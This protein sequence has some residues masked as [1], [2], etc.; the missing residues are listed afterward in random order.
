[1]VEKIKSTP[2][3]NWVRLLAVLICGA[4]VGCITTARISPMEELLVAADQAKTR[5]IQL[6]L[7]G[8]YNIDPDVDESGKRIV[9]TSNKFG[10]FDLF[11]YDSDHRARRRLTRHVADD[12]HPALTADG[13]KVAFV[14]RRDD[15][16]GDIYYRD[17]QSSAWVSISAE[18]KA[19]NR[20]R[21]EGY[22]DSQPT[23]SPNNKFIYFVRRKLGATRE[24][25]VRYSLSDHSVTVI[26][27]GLSPA[28]SSDG[29]AMAFSRRGSIILRNL[30]NGKEWPLAKPKIVVDGH[31]S[32]ARSGKWLYFSRYNSDSNRDRQINGDDLPIISRIRLEDMRHSRVFPAE[33]LT[34]RNLRGARPRGISGQR[35]LFS[36][37]RADTIEVYGALAQN[38]RQ[39]SNEFS[40]AAKDHHLEV[41]RGQV[42]AALQN[43]TLKNKDL[44]IEAVIWG[45]YLSALEGRS[46]DVELFGSYADQAGSLDGRVKTVLRTA[47]KVMQ[48]YSLNFKNFDAVAMLQAPV[49]SASKRVARLLESMELNLKTVAKDIKL[50]SRLGSLLLLMRAKVA[51]Y[52]SQYARALKLLSSAPRFSEPRLRSERII[53]SALASSK[54]AGGDVGIAALIGATQ[55]P[56]IS[57]RFKA[58]LSEIIVKTAISKGDQ[59]FRR[60]ERLE[61]LAQKAPAVVSAIR[62]ER[63]RQF[64]KKSQHFLA[65]NELETVLTQPADSYPLA[66][67]AARAWIKVLQ[68]ETNITETIRTAEQSWKEFRGAKPETKKKAQQLFS[69]FFTR[70]GYSLMSMGEPGGAASVFKLASQIWPQNIDSWRGLVEANFMRHK[71]TN[72]LDGWCQRPRKTHSPGLQMYLCGL[73]TSYK[74]DASDDD[75]EKLNWCEQAIELIQ[76]SV[77]TDPSLASAHQ[78]LGW[79]YFQRHQLNARI[80]SK[81]PMRRSFRKVRAIVKDYL[82]WR[83]SDD[84]VLAIDS[85]LSS[86]Y[87]AMPDSA[88][89]VLLS[90]NLAGVFFERKN[91]QQALHYY[92]LR[93]AA[94]KEVPFPSKKV[95]Q[96]FMF[97][98]ARSGYQSSEYDLASYFARKAIQIAATRGDVA[99]QSAYN[100]YLNLVFLEAKKFKAC[101]AGTTTSQEVYRES[102][103]VFERINAESLKAL[104]QLRAEKPAQA[105]AQAYK[106]LSLLDENPKAAVRSRAKITV[107]IGGEN[108][109]IVEFDDFMRQLLLY[110]I[111]AD[112]HLQQQNIGA[113]INVLEQKEKMIA[114][115]VD[116][117]RKINGRSKN[118]ALELAY[119]RSNLAGAHMKLGQ[120]EFARAAASRGFL[121]LYRA[122]GAALKDAAL[123][124]LL[125]FW[126]LAQEHTNSSD[127]ER[128]QLLQ[129]AKDMW[130]PYQDIGDSEKVDQ[131]ERQILLAT[132]C[133]TGWRELGETFPCQSRNEE[134]GDQRKSK[135]LKS[136]GRARQGMITDQEMKATRRSMFAEVDY[137]LSYADHLGLT[138]IAFDEILIR[139]REG[140]N[141]FKDLRSKQLRGVLED[142]IEQLLKARQDPTSAVCQIHDSYAESV[143][144]SFNQSREAQ[145]SNKTLQGSFGLI[146][147]ALVQS[148]LA[149]YFDVFGDYAA[150]IAVNSIEHRVLVGPKEGIAE[151]LMKYLKDLEQSNGTL[152]AVTTEAIYPMILDLTNPVR[153]LHDLRALPTFKSR[154]QLIR[155]VTQTL[156]APSELRGK[157]APP[158]RVNVNRDFNQ[159]ADV[160]VI[161][162]EFKP[163]LADFSQS[164]FSQKDQG[165][166]VK[167]A[168][169]AGPKGAKAAQLIVVK[170]PHLPNDLRASKVAFLR[171]LSAFTLHINAAS[172][173][174]DFKGRS[175]AKSGEIIN[176]FTSHKTISAQGLADRGW[177]MVGHTG[178][179]QA[180][181]VAVARKKHEKFY[182]RFSELM[183][184]GQIV[185]AISS[186]MNALYCAELSEDLEGMEDTL[187]R[188]IRA[189]YAS[190]DYGRAY[191]LQ[192]KQIAL[193]EE[194]EYDPEEVLELKKEL[195]TIAI[196]AGYITKAEQLLED[197][198]ISQGGKAETLQLKAMVAKTRGQ[199]K[200]AFEFIEASAAI[201][202][203]EEMP[204]LAIER[205]MELGNIEREYFG[206]YSA[207]V[208][209]YEKA[210]GFAEAN[211]F[212]ILKAQIAI[213]YANTLIAIG[214]V[215][216]AQALL[217]KQDFELLRTRETSSATRLKMVLANASYLT[218][219][220][221]RANQTL[222]DIES[223]LSQVEDL[224]KRT[225]LGIDAANLRAMILCR[226]GQFEDCFAI[227]RANIQAAN[228]IGDSRKKTEALNNIGFWLREKGDYDRSVSELRLALRIDQQGK[229]K[230]AVAYDLRNLAMTEAM[231]NNLSEAKSLIKRSIEMS[232]ELRMSYNLAQSHLVLGDVLGRSKEFKASGEEFAK[233]LAVAKSAGLTDLTWRAQSALGRLYLDAKETPKAIESFKQAVETLGRL[234]TGLGSAKSRSGF[235]SDQGFNAVFEG[236]ISALVQAKEHKK[237]WKV[238]QNYRS[239]SFVES[240]GEITAVSTPQ[241]RKLLR[242]RIRLMTEIESQ[243]RRIAVIDVKDSKRIKLEES[244]DAL[245]GDL[246]IIKDKIIRADP[247]AL[248]VIAD[249]PVSEL[250]LQKILANNSALIDYMVTQDRIHTWVINKQKF[251][252]VGLEISREELRLEMTRFQSVI[253]NLS[254]YELTLSRL[255][256]MLFSPLAKLVAGIEQ[257]IIIPSDVLF[258]LP[259]AALI[260]DRKFLLDQFNITYLEAVAQLSGGAEEKTKFPPNSPDVTVFA[261]PDRPDQDPLPFAA[262]EGLSIQRVF[263]KGKY[264]LGAEAT[265]ERMLA[266]PKSNILHIASHGYFDA[267]EPNASGLM[268]GGLDGEPRNLTVL[269]ILDKQISGNLTVVS[270]CESGLGSL[271]RG[272]EIVSLNRA[273]F[274]AGAQKVISSFWRISDVASAVTMK[275]FYRYLG[276]SSDIDGSLSQAQKDVRRYFAHPAFWAAFKASGSVTP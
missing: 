142:H 228:K 89:R 164:Y 119:L 31:P 186:G 29:A 56:D 38:R 2:L 147:G 35:F 202:L 270:A 151:L 5:A 83:D 95:A 162:G 259:F 74:I 128:V 130:A 42:A 139:L 132:I 204:K 110:S 254:S 156:E 60:L 201:L 23:W 121:D 55:S 211:E 8:M 148:D 13:G 145:S 41:A 276:T 109:T 181:I 16:H 123:R 207:A 189:L 47:T 248:S 70:R 267:A 54:L 229:N 206:N 68:Q 17:L 64:R 20:I 129:A 37:K 114:S 34:D 12:F 258:R 124:R 45:Q 247:K 98:A 191:A 157:S 141:F 185:E 190:N 28:I 19:A 69:K 117:K 115:S 24:S 219:E 227:M 80:S 149:L 43:Q 106:T 21:G 265:I 173:F 87:L 250:E 167:I 239:R 155:N 152:Y 136:V 67:K 224:S 94:E 163:I 169:L 127:K 138:K 268:L 77:F 116:A 33:A 59:I 53:L 192:I 6:S 233:G 58:G 135:L 177:W 125:E 220:Y 195:V 18:E 14:S 238:A 99:S 154:G 241:V 88:Q 146:Q 213:D 172:A 273:F 180:D 22:I 174:V 208:A 15:A 134:F 193:A 231:R 263:S 242:Q 272:D 112:T 161:E 100:D 62:L 243:S 197:P 249:R 107:G 66:L 90:Q 102:G 120:Y 246:A 153:W 170:N 93:I 176:K 235:S 261:N 209:W 9:F 188:L 198:L 236:Y 205:W 251:N 182:G 65:S 44:L 71:N 199:Y 232:T 160:I 91:F 218:G 50:D 225:V 166:C 144:V 25:I 97:S 159:D 39:I 179:E 51:V 118:F 275:R 96:R 216:S 260:T 1:M 262:K 7:G 73:A 187:S 194:Q 210:Y 266:R 269:D 84:R 256:R 223:L 257:L 158:S 200:K 85:Y 165:C 184:Q 104:C 237:A 103:K 26:T 215:H 36:G 105:R 212:Q 82:G 111:I 3:Q 10:N 150:L 245:M 4:L 203:K 222:I 108:Q 61:Q 48:A 230:I 255:G 171:S 240:L 57:E 52:S 234:R 271:S 274:I 244:R 168:E 92:S 131:A 40:F 32:F 46:L 86:F 113:L 78:T 264:Y 140:Q 143:E 30:V 126:I 133:L 76:D 63:A 81:D 49:T 72:V 183:D 252:Y 196:R 217:K 137:R 214:Q 27:V 226:L 101:I 11:L 75:R 253:S 175:S 178:T 221:D 79:L 122:S